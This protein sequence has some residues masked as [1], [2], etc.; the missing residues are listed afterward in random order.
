MLGSPHASFPK[1]VINPR[2]RAEFLN[3]GTA[4]IHGQVIL[5]C[6]SC[7]LPCRILSSIPGLSTLDARSSPSVVTIKNICRHYHTSSGG[8]DLSRVRATGTEL[9]SCPSP[10][11]EAVVQS[12][13]GLYS[14]SYSYQVVEAG[15]RG[16]PVTPK[17]CIMVTGECILIVKTA[18]STFDIPGLSSV[19][20]MLELQTLFSGNLGE[21]PREEIRWSS[22]IGRAP[23]A[24]RTVSHVADPWVCFSLPSGVLQFWSHPPKDMSK[25][26][27][28]NVLFG[29]RA[30]ADIIKFRWSHQGR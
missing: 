17:P 30:T 24:N 14:E 6:V 26:W 29:N 13:Y 16:C 28:L 1:P 11:E 15:F 20:K 19:L 27:P 10:C 21:A 3:L 18:S 5:G 12:G 23:R 9:V 22:F 4:N 2:G 25:S 8:Q 7:L